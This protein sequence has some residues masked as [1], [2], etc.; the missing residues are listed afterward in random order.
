[1]KEN[2]KDYEIILGKDEY[3]IVEEY[4]IGDLVLDDLTNQISKV[5]Q[6]TPILDSIQGICDSWKGNWIKLDNDYLDGW[7]YE[8]EIMKVRKK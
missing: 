7:R 3:P 2:P 5:I 4:K 1:M 6:I 8:W